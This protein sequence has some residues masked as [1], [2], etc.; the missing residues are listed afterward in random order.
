MSFVPTA[1]ATIASKAPQFITVTGKLDKCVVTQQKGQYAHLP[2]KYAVFTVI[3]GEGMV[4]VIQGELADISQL[5]DGK[6]AGDTVQVS[7]TPTAFVLPSGQIVQ[8]NNLAMP[9]DDITID[10]ESDQQ[11]VDEGSAEVQELV[12]QS[13][14]DAQQDMLDASN[15]EHRREFRSM[16]NLADD[17]E[18]DFDDDIPF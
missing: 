4:H 2:P 7:F 16:D 15:S 5:F 17:V 13:K 9:A 1:Q 18:S 10:Q 3:I 14:L 8:N 6:E 12:R 11:Q